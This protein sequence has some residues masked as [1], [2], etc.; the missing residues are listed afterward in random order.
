MTKPQY[1]EHDETPIWAAD[2]PSETTVERSGSKI[3]PIKTTGHDKHC[4]TVC[5][6]VNGESLK[7]M[8]F[9]L[10]PG[11]IIKSEVSVV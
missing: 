2:M 1:S 3:V 11:T 9:I 8:P 5:L 10:I 6:A 4:I 7:M